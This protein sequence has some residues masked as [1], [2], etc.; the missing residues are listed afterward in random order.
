MDATGNIFIDDA[1]IK[2]INLRQAC[3]HLN[4]SRYVSFY[5]N[6]FQKHHMLLSFN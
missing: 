5:N 4:N 3:L 1:I 6:C 2:K